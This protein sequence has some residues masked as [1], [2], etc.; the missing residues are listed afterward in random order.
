MGAG[1]PAGARRSDP[2]NDR[3]AAVGAPRRH[4]SRACGPA[5]G[6]AAWTLKTRRIPA[7]VRRPRERWAPE[8]TANF[9]AHP[10]A[11][12]AGGAVRPLWR[13]SYSF[14]LRRPECRA[15][16]GRPTISA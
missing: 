14:R 15:G 3:V 12:D 1:Y 8:I 7:K 2:P 13:R 10:L 9:H 4:F 6:R 16:V 11:A 5:D